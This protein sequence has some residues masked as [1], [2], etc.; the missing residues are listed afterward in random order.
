MLFYGALISP[1]S[2]TAYTAAPH[3]LVSV[4]NDTGVIE[5][6]EE[7]VPA[8]TLQDTLAKH[9]VVDTELTELKRGEFLMPGLIDTHT[10]SKTLPGTEVAAEL[11]SNIA[12]TAST[13]RGPVGL[14]VS[15]VD[16]S[17]RCLVG[18]S[19]SFSTGWRKSRSLWKQGTK[20][21]PSRDV[22]TKASCGDS[23][24]VVCVR[25]HRVV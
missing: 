14:Q 2:L 25:Y 23:S 16:T 7:D 12:C 1:T 21:Q 15:L 9:G 19:T 3:A 18:R 8:H 22:Y 24:T 4:S 6:V 20:T 10:V 17:D 13:K 11:T 5:W